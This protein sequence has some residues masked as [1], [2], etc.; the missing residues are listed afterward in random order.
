MNKILFPEI[1]KMLKASG[2]EIEYDSNPKTPYVGFY[3]KHNWDHGYETYYGY[4]GR[5]REFYSDLFTVA[6][7]LNE[8]LNNAA[9]GSL[10]VFPFY[11]AGAFVHNYRYCESQYDII[12]EIRSFLK[13]NDISPRSKSGSFINV[14]EKDKIL[15]ILEGA[16]RGVSQLCLFSAERGIV[17]EPDHHFQVCIWTANPQ[18][19]LETLSSS[20]AKFEDL[21]MFSSTETKN[22]I[23]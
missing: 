13:D 11:H 6:S 19:E 10:L 1:R 20:I 5:R 7:C 2:L 9:I 14:S 3:H 8:Y 12:D 17:I 21:S 18:K 22:S 16:F 23:E 15:M 4:N